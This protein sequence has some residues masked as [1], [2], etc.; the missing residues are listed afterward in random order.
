MWD[1]SPALSTGHA[2]CYTETRRASHIEI[3]AYEPEMAEDLVSV[4]NRA[5]DSVPHCYPATLEDFGAAL[6]PAAGQG[7]SHERLHS[8]AAFVARDQGSLLGFVNVA[9]ERPKGEEEVERGVIRFLC[10]PR[11]ER[12]LGQSLLGA[13]EEYLRERGI[14][15]VL[16]HHQDYRYR[17]YHFEH[18]YL[19]DR[20]EHV[21][22]LLA[23]NGYEKCAGEVFLDWP[24]Y[25]P[26]QPATVDFPTEIAV[27]WR[28]GRG[29]RPGVRVRALGE[30]RQLGEC[31][32]LSG[33]E[34]SDEAD[35]Q[36]WFHVVWLGIEDAVQ[37]RGL[38]RHLLQRTL[39]E[40][41]G[42]GYR[43][44]CISTHW[45]NPRALL[46]YSNYGFHMVDW[47]YGFRRELG[48]AAA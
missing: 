36:D 13:A 9:V 26:P 22:A 16:V 32:C 24:D 29:A 18:A 41:H 20:L 44:A 3:T 28:E 12:G 1:P 40:L 48:A 39:M 11:G 37:G 6:S 45:D 15:E 19:S 42:R 8:E 33:G 17:F 38:G 34:W 21:Q 30:G 2:G 14:A 47:T 35:A 27:E 10:Y 23:F 43:H 5:V 31:V 25:D 46:F 7:V 4:Y